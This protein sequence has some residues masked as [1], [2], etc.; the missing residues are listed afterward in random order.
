MN[1]YDA[2]VH[3][4]PVKLTRHHQSLVP[5]DQLLKLSGGSSAPDRI[6][7]DFDPASQL[8]RQMQTSLGGA[9]LFFHDSSG[10]HVIGVL[11]RSLADCAFDGSLA[12]PLKPSTKSSKKVA[13]DRDAALEG[14]KRLGGDLIDRIELQRA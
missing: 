11:F 6:P 12:Y 9:A 8:V 10:G 5:S 13:L 7:V 14:V 4:N 3:L 1:E 2:V